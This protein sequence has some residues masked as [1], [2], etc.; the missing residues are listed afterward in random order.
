M[1]LWQDVRPDQQGFGS[2]Q[3]TAALFEVIPRRPHAITDLVSAYRWSIASWPRYA[4]RCCDPP[5]SMGPTCQLHMPHGPLGCGRRGG[6][7]TQVSSTCSS[8]SYTITQQSLLQSKAFP[9]FQ[10]SQSLTFALKLPTLNN[11]NQ[12][13]T[14]LYNR[15]HAHRSH[16]R[17]RLGHGFYRACR[18]RSCCGC[19][20]CSRR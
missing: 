8:T 17:F 20:R 3:T 7:S 12:P 10:E 19:C 6:I 13:I 5:T 4:M 9:W 15:Q 1:S 2:Q 11:N 16:L 18:T 14:R